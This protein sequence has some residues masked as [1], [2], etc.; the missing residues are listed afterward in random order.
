[1]RFRDCSLGFTIL[2]SEGNI[3]SIERDHIVHFVKENYTGENMVV[4][5]VG[6]VDHKDFVRYVEAHFAKVK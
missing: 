2:G 3:K 4:V 5:G 6:D 1:M